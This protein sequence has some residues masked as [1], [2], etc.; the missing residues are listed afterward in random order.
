LED[1]SPVAVYISEKVE[2][3]SS[4]IFSTAAIKRLKLVRG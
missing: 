1:F 4:N 3:K 2:S